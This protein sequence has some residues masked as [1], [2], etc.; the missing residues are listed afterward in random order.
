MVSLVIIVLLLGLCY[1]KTYMSKPTKS[2]ELN[3]EQFFDNIER[4]KKGDDAKVHKPTLAM[5]N[6]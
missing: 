4:A 2:V 6:V 5:S 3:E 1:Y